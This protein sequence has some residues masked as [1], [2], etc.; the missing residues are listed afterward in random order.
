MLYSHHP[1]QVGG[2]VNTDN[3]CNKE[4]CL[5]PVKALVRMSANCESVDM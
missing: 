5:T 2:D 1:P 3:L 4:L